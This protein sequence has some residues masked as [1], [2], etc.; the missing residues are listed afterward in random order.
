MVKSKVGELEEEGWAE[1]SRRLRKELNS[2]VQ[3]VSWKRSFLVR[4]KDV[5]EK[6]LTLNKLSLV[7]LDKIP[8][9]EEPG[10][11][12]ISGIPDETVDL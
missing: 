7:T 1:F 11:H 6:Y 3:L 9:D 10:M 2:L 5:R 4:F 12:M 8:V